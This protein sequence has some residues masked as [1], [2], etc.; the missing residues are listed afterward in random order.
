MVNSVDCTPDEGGQRHRIDEM[1]KCRVDDE[2]R[3]D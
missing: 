1:D 3:M 2:V